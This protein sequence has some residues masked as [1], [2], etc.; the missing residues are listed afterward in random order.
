MLKIEE[1]TI[2]FKIDE[3]E[4]TAVDGL[5]LSVEKNDF[6]G[7]VGE[8]GC[9]KSVTALSIMRLLPKPYGNITAGKIFF[10]EKNLLEL[11]AKEMRGVRGKQIS[12]IFQ[13]PMTSLSPLH[14]VYK[15]LSESLI[16]HGK[17]MNTIEMRELAEN[18]LIKVGISDP[19]NKLEAYPFELS[20]GMRQ[21]IMIAMALIMQP[22]LLIA[23]EPT[24]A[25]DV[26]VQAQIMDI[27]ADMR[28]QLGLTVILITHDLSIVAQVCNKAA[29]M[30]SG[31]IVETASVKDL[32]KKPAHPYTRGLLKAIPVIGNR[33][34]KLY[35]IPG[36]V[37]ALNEL[38]NK[39]KCC[40]ADRCEYKKEICETQRPLL[41]KV[42]EE[43]YCACWLI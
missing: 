2:K 25:L 4:F 28:E 33:S 37:P 34:R 23:D 10:D 15:Q 41:K 43:H 6:F 16:A 18:W 31:R 9:G 14:R 11:P 30:Y 32:F 1:L 26:T 29:V 42:E 40:F 39:E 8:S 22:N 12:M 38:R 21:R 17:K 13:E 3:G 19:E 5:S 20:G 35:S 24:T 27:I 7:L 36:F